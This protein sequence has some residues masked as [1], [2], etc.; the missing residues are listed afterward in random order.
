MV[1]YID[2]PQPIILNPQPMVM[3]GLSGK[4]QHGKDTVFQLMSSVWAHRM[5][6]RFAFADELKRMAHLSLGVTG[7]ERQKEAMRPLY[8]FL[9][10]FARSTFGDDFWVNKVATAVEAEQR[11]QLPRQITP[12]VTDVR[13]PNEMR[14]IKDNGGYV[15]RVFKW[16]P[17]AGD[18]DRHASECLLDNAAFDYGIWAKAGDMMSL[19][20]QVISICVDIDSKTLPFETQ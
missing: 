19:R 16:T 13:F 12:V 20:K 5:P 14:F 10:T 6:M 2:K 8:Q 17:D 7:E 4:K 1:T 18:D 3:I 15:I 11:R 9:G